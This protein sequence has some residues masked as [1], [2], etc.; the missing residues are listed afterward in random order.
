MH[1]A[2]AAARGP[3][4]ARRGR[5]PWTGGSAAISRRTSSPPDRVPLL[6]HHLLVL[7]H[8]PCCRTVPQYDSSTAP[9]FALSRQQPRTTH[10]IAERLFYAT[11]GYQLLPAIMFDYKEGRGQGKRL[12]AT[13]QRARGCCHHLG[14]TGRPGGPRRAARAAC[15]HWDLPA[16]MP[17]ARGGARRAAW[18]ALG[19]ACMHESCWLAG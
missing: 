11:S 18:H 15:M 10:I 5:A 16:C 12:P 4:P 14:R 6:A 3:A 13:R 9:R 1:A 7:Q 17:A 8:R 19:F 2:R